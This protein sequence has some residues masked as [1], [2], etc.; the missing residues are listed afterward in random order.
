MDRGPPSPASPP[1]SHHHLISA[2]CL[3]TRVN[4]LR[5]HQRSRKKGP[6]PPKSQSRD[7]R[8]R[9][10]GCV[11]SWARPPVTSH[12][13]Q[14]S[15]PC[16]CPHFSCQPTRGAD[17]KGD[18]LV[19]RLGREKGSPAPSRTLW[20]SLGLM[21]P[22][23]WRDHC[24]LAPR[25]SWA[26]GDTP[27]PTPGMRGPLGQN[28]YLRGPGPDAPRSRGKTGLRA[29]QAGPRMLCKADSGSLKSFL[30]F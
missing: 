29:L 6:E 2:P 25:L 30:S 1:T 26:T 22:W 11:D 27:A 13:R 16:L 17:S 7:S 10:A 28:W 21:L 15:D 24:S 14:A 4:P 5:A 3:H 18:L 8:R 12:T 19:S 20:A 9:P 23:S